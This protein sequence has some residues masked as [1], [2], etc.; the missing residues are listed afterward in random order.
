MHASVITPSNGF[1]LNTLLQPLLIP[2]LPRSRRALR[3]RACMLLSC[4]RHG[5]RRRACMLSCMRH[6]LEHAY[7]FHAC[8]TVYGGEHACC[9]HACATVCGGEHACCCHACA[10]VYG[11]EHVCCCHAYT[12]CQ[13]PRQP[14]QVMQPGHNGTHSISMRSYIRS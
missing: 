5:L 14:T 3:R 6:G 12:G 2:T 11:G 8:A 10:T 4:M 1:D 13:A 9:C 7:C